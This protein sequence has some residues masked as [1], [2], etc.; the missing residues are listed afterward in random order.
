MEIVV[1]EREMDAMVNVLQ[2]RP[3]LV[4]PTVPVTPVPDKANVTLLGVGAEATAQKPLNIVPFPVT[5]VIAI[6][7]PATAFIGVEN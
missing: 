7:I 2:S 1:P 6:C 5:L 3:M 4:A